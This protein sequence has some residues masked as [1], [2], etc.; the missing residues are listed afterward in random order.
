MMK[1]MSLA[2]KKFAVSS[3]IAGAGFIPMILF[4]C[5]DMVVYLTALYTMGL[6]IIILLNG[7]NKKVE[8]CG[9]K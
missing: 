1:E 7:K 5:N 2:T 6:I 4:S 3:M 9:K 8:P